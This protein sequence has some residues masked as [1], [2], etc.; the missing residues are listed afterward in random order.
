MTTDLTRAALRELSLWIDQGN[1]HR[2]GEAV[3]W[4]RI[5][6]VGEEFGEAV[7]AVI[8]A[9]G[10]NPRKGVTHKWT[11]V[12]DELLDVAVTA[13]GAIE[14]LRR[15]DGPSALDLLEVK[16][17]A[18]ATRAGVLKVNHGRVHAQGRRICDECGEEY[19]YC[20]G[21]HTARTEPGGSGC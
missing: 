6:K 12:E 11:D 18:V 16:I 17:Q 2:D 9:T 10:Q 20:G 19:A 3:M 4:G 5:T 15:H 14:H 21:R 13:L 1:A 7:A 8:G